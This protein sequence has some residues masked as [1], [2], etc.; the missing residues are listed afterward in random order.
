MSRKIQTAPC[1]RKSANSS[2]V[3]TIALPGSNG[4]R[5]PC[6]PFLWTWLCHEIFTLCYPPPKSKPSAA[7]VNGPPRSVE[8]VI[9][10]SR[11]PPP[12]RYFMH[13]ELRPL[14]CARRNCHEAP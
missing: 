5:R 2:K 14:E 7:C 4:G 8:D 3:R 13:R 10:S 9:P 11:N 12:A 6:P 1:P